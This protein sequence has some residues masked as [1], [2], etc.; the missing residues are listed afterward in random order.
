MYLRRHRRTVEGA[1]YEY[2]ALVESRRTASGPRQHTVATL[3]KLPGLDK[4]VQANWDTI[5]DLLEGRTPARQLELSGEAQAPE[6]LWREVN[7]RSVRVERVREFGQLYLAL[8]LWR[9]LGLHSLLNELIPSGREEVAWERTACLLT[10]AR[11]CAQPKKGQSYN[12]II[13]ELTLERGLF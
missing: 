3:G 12:I 5:D 2:W 9:R 4:K 11:F 10:I 8:S 1:T 13:L 7:V 6:R